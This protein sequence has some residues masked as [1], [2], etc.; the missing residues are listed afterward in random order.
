MVAE[1]AATV[2][3]RP[4]VLGQEK[5]LR[6]NQS[7]DQ[8][9]LDGGDEVSGFGEY[10]TEQFQLSA[11]FLVAD[12]SAKGS[13][14]EAFEHFLGVCFRP[15]A[16]GGIEEQALVGFR[17]PAWNIVSLE[18]DG[19]DEDRGD[20]EVLWHGPALVTHPLTGVFVTVVEYEVGD[21]SFGEAVVVGMNLDVGQVTLRE[22]E[23]VPLGLVGGGGDL[24]VGE[25]FL[26]DVD[27]QQGGAE[28]LLDFGPALT[29]RR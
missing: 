13:R 28:P 14:H 29:R 26:E 2:S 8:G 3:D 17:W 20:R 18:L 7:G 19:V 9:F 24:H 21:W 1:F 16:V 6:R 11:Y 25:Q 23:L 27:G 22:H 4:R 15:V 10:L 12:R 5:E